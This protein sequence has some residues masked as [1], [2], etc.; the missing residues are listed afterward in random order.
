MNG[1]KLRGVDKTKLAN[2]KNKRPRRFNYIKKKKSL[3]SQKVEL[4][5]FPAKYIPTIT[6]LFT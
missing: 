3:Q 5:T 4:C 1:F 6:R 2:K